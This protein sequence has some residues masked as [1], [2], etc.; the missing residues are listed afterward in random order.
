MGTPYAPP[1]RDEWVTT[2]N[3][4]L[5]RASDLERVALS[6]MAHEMAR[7]AVGA[8]QRG[9]LER[10]DILKKAANMIRRVCVMEE[11]EF[12]LPKDPFDAQ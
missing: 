10:A 3:G 8:E 2:G 9:D 6:S 5:I 1:R 7:R 4:P 11:F 12:P